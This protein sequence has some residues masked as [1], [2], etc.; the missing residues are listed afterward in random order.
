M[1]Q[2]V[3]PKSMRLGVVQD[4]D[5]K[6]YGSNK[7]YSDILLEDVKIR[8]YI[9]KSLYHAGIA[10]ILIERV[11]K[12]ITITIH[13]GKPGVVIGRGGSE[14]EKL[15]NS[16]KSMVKGHQINIKV[17]EVKKPEMEAQLIAENIAA[18]LEKRISF[19][20][21]VKQAVQRAMKIGAGGIRVAVSGRLGG[22]EIARTEWYS[23]GKVPLHTIRA[24]VVY[25]TA[26]ADTT[27]GK[28]G[29]KTWVYLGDILTEEKNRKLRRGS[30][31]C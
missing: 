2:K 18:Q 3:H 20:R 30:E 4:W 15:R 21:A 24:N 28:I 13:T 14:I 26:E 9:K 23:E 12:R 31:S 7:D 25:A 17:I 10:R 29:V 19:R 1:G 22:A 27:Y 16:L 8:E 5:A 11:G 6:W